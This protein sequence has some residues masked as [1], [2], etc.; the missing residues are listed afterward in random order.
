MTDAPLNWLWQA[1]L[2]M[3]PAHPI[4]LFEVKT[5]EDLKTSQSNW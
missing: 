1:D 4:T 2:I 3:N 5:C